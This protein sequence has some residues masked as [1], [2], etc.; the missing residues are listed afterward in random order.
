MENVQRL[1]SPSLQAQI[2]KFNR[3]SKHLMELKYIVYITINLCN[4]KFYIGVHKTNPETFDGYIGN[5]IYRQSDATENYPFHR[6]VKKY[7]YENFKRTI[8]K[9][10]PNTDEGMKAAYD[11][12]G[13]LVN[14]TLLRSKNV[15]NLALGGQGSTHQ[16]DKKRVYQFDLNGNY[17]RSFDCV[18][19]AA[20]YLQQ[21]D[22]YATLKAIRNN[23]L[24]TTNSSFGYFWS[25]TKKFDYKINRRLRKVAQY[26]ISGKFLRYFDSISEAERELHINTIEQAIIKKYTAGG[27][28]WKYYE[29]DDSDIPTLLSLK[30]KNKILPISMFTKDMQKVKDFN[31]V[32][33]CVKEYPDL[34]ASQINRVLNKVIKS[35]K[36]YI[37][38]YQDEDIVC[39]N[40]K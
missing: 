37:F 34:S 38:K 22:E 12:E 4:G 26:T 5:S 18:R 20:R 16:E 6:A 32:N 30:T 39:S 7:G 19:S 2:K 14:E 8:I 31:C 35:H 25:Y 23:C 29:N 33:D 11:L 17:L 9:T 27:Y 1:V 36:G 28:Q 13:V 15:Y 3:N 10:F 21:D 24:G 40:Q